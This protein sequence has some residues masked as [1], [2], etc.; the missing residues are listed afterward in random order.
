MQLTFNL[1]GLTYLVKTAY[2]GEAWLGE[3]SNGYSGAINKAQWCYSTNG[4]VTVFVFKNDDLDALVNLKENIRNIYGKGKHT[5]HINDTHLESIEL[6]KLLFNE[7]SIK[8]ANTARFKFFENISKFLVDFKSV[9]SS[10]NIS[11][12]CFVI[13]GSVLSAYGIRD[14]NDFDYLH[15]LDQSLQGF[16]FMDG[17]E[18]ELD[19]L[20]WLNT[21]RDDVIYNPENHFYFE[22]VKFL[23][24][25]N[26]LKIKKARLRD[27]DRNEI[28]LIES[29]LGAEKTYTFNYRD[30]LLPLVQLAFWKIRIKTILLKLRYW[31]FRFLSL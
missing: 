5:I 6:A 3:A 31:Y 25:K 11:T 1:V 26:T 20:N 2:A 28:H 17:V 16:G 27:A 24:L 30:R 15:S 4:A 14:C 10:K 18:P 13:M 12:D 21:S 29:L 8:W 23:S 9:C 19:K 22:G 7:N